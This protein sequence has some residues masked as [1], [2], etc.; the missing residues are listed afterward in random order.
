MIF[1]EKFIN[2]K[3]EDIV[4]SL[5]TDGYYAIENALTE[6]FIFS[7]ESDVS[8]HRFLTN[9]NIL[10]GG[11][12]DSQYFLVNMLA[13]SQVF[14]N[15]CTNSKVLD[16]CEDVIGNLFRLKALRYYESYGN[17]RMQWHTDSKTSEGFAS[18]PGLIFIAYITDVFDG[19][20][21]YVRGSHEWSSTKMQ[22]DFAQEF[23]SEDVQSFKM[24]KGS[25]I[26]YNT[27]GIHRAKPSDSSNFIRKSLFFQVDGNDNSEPFLINPSFM[28]DFDERIRMYLGFGREATNTPF[29]YTDETTI[30]DYELRNLISK[31][32][33]DRIKFMLR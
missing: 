19:E 2:T 25:V 7:I 29:P 20:F 32:G 12:T 30:P 28:S 21:Q 5:N 16:I 10:S 11:Y 3:K 22:N 8:N 24:P 13:C 6:D 26:I 9:S 18:I 15:Y 33:Y 31:V 14:F 23:N 4:R 1:T 17:T 27:H